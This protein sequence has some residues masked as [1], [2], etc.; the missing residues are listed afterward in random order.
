MKGKWKTG[1][2]MIAG[3]LLGAL[4]VSM[5]S[6][7]G[8][9]GR[10][11]VQL[12]EEWIEEKTVD[13]GSESDVPKDESAAASEAKISD[14]ET[15]VENGASEAESS[16][17]ETNEENAASEA[18]PSDTE[19]NEENADPAEYYGNET[20][21]DNPAEYYGNETETDDTGDIVV[22]NYYPECSQSGL[23]YKD[24]PFIHEAVRD[25]E[26]GRTMKIW[27]VENDELVETDYERTLR[28]KTYSYG[29]TLDFV[30]TVNLPVSPDGVNIFVTDLFS[31]Y[32]TSTE[33]G[34]WVAEHGTGYSLYIITT[35][36][37]GDIYFR[38]YTDYKSITE[39]C[40]QGCRFPRDLLVTVFGNDREVRKFDK[41]FKEELPEAIAYE[42]IHVN[43]PDEPDEKDDGIVKLHAAPCFEKNISNVKY[44]ETNICWGLSEQELIENLTWSNTF[45]FKKSGLSAS[46]DREKVKAVLYGDTDVPM[47]ASGTPEISVKKYNSKEKCWENDR[48]SFILNVETVTDVMHASENSK[49]NSKV[50]GDL[51]TPAEGH[52]AIVLALETNDPDKGTY[53]IEV[54]QKV[55]EVKEEENLTVW[56]DESDNSI[57]ETENSEDPIREFVENQAGYGEYYKALETECKDLGHGTYKYS[58]F[59]G[60]DSALARL[61]DLKGMVG[62]LTSAGAGIVDQE[63]RFRVLITIN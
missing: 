30:T 48:Q 50:G 25:A 62:E 45:S 3:A 49:I 10:R 16:D 9:S 20:E 29:S 19:T 36:Y 47:E 17:T 31:N 15:N 54:R 8:A 59:N 22:D 33:F 42:Y 28:P 44:D 60:N 39:I 2:K 5:I 1:K 21:T 46:D 35:D 56:T 37:N 63:I 18:E 13:T 43:R 27:A 11:T 40:I 57:I 58:G 38:D 61:L 12:P 24:L 6:G 41:R 4:T 55:R 34:R 32:V 14:T 26:I 53:A 51:I 7:C 52:G 23:A